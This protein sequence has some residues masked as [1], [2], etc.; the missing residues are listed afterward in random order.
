M[1][2]AVKSIPNFDKLSSVSSPVLESI[3]LPDLKFSSSFLNSKIS[4][5]LLKISLISAFSR[6]AEIHVSTA[7]N[8]SP[9]A[10]INPFAFSKEFASS[11]E[12]LIFS[13]LT[14]EL[15]GKFEILL[16]ISSS[17]AFAFISN[18]LKI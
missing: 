15:V 9:V 7:I 17:T 13:L 11:F 16:F 3:F 1:A 8:L 14:F 12:I 10:L 4:Q 6:L 18:L 5:N 2:F